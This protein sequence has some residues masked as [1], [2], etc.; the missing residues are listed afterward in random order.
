MLITNLH[1]SHR[2]VGCL[3]ITH[4]CVNDIHY[5]EF[6]SNKLSA[7]VTMSL[8]L[9][10]TLPGKNTRKPNSEVGSHHKSPLHAHVTFQCTIHNIQHSLE[11]LGITAAPFS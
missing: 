2:M 1:L 11:N 9:H 4:K 10:L 6:C 7:H 8:L 5:M 3:A